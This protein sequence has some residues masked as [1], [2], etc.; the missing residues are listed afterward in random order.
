MSISKLCIER[1]VL[2]IVMNLILLIV[3]YIGFDRLN[4]RELPKTEQFT[5]QISTTYR[6]ASADLV[7]TQIT[8]PIEDRIAGVEGIDVIS[9]TSSSGVSNITITFSANYNINEGMNDVRDQLSRVRKTLPDEADDPVLIKADPNTVP[10]LYIGFGDTKRDALALT[11]YVER[12]IKPDLTQV[13]GVGNVIVYGERRY[14]VRIWP[15]PLKMAARGVTVNDIQAML[16]SQN[17]ALPSGDIKSTYRN[18]TINTES[19]LASI[20]EFRDLIIRDDDNKMVHLTDV[21]DVEIGPE[22]EDTAVRV[23]GAS[24]VVLA[25][26]PQTTA[27]PVDVSNKVQIRL[28]E[29]QRSLPEGMSA[30]VNY[31][32]AT[33]IRASIHEVY[34][35]IYEAIILVTLVV[36]AFLG[37][38]RSA[39]IPIVTIPL[40]LLTTFGVVYA[41][42]YT[43]NTMTLLAMVLAIGLVVDDAI[44][45][46]ENVYRYIEKGDKPM[47][48]AIKGSQEISFAIVAMTLTLAA[49]YAPIGFTQGFTG[50]IF[51]E[52][53]FTLAGAVIISGFVALT[54]SPM[55]CARILPEQHAKNKY[56][57]WVESTFE[58]LTHRYREFINQVLIRRGMVVILFIVIAA[59][60]VLGF[61]SL[62]SELAPHE[63]QGIIVSYVTA[64]TGASFRYTD[65]VMTQLEKVLM[66]V[67]ERE[68]LVLVV[69]AGSTSQGIA[70][71]ALKDWDA[72]KRSQGD[73]AK[74]LM[75]QLMHIPG[76]LMVAL[77]LPPI[78]GSNT[79]RTP[80]DFVIQVSGSYDELYDITERFKTALSQY[81]GLNSVEVDL[82]MDSQQVDVTIDRELAANL[83]IDFGDISDALNI[84]FAGRHIT[85]FESGGENYDVMVQLREAARADPQQLNN[86]YVRGKTGKI[87][88]LA[89]LITFK[90]AVKPNTLPHYNRMRA[91][92]VTANVSAGYALGD[93]ITA[94]EDIA[95]K[96]LPL[97]AKYDWAG[98][99]K[100]FL[101]S[102]GAMG[103]TVV[104]A[105]IF[106]YLVLAAQFES[107]VD[108][109]IIMLTVP[110]SIIGAVITLKLTGGSN[111][112]YTQIGFVTL[113][114]LITK[115]GI[116]MVD[117]ANAARARGFDKYQAVI[118]AGVTR[119]RP[120]LMTTG[121][122]VLGAIPLA[123]ATGPGAEARSQMGWV[124]V[125][126]ML[127][128]TLFSL[129]VVPTIY[130]Y[131]SRGK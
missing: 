114:G 49:V 74:A 95:A 107:F 102:S 56:V 15:D 5:L 4:V 55:M 82:K 118:E 51:R 64:P 71:M 16:V 32:N 98:F 86:I 105:L 92:R 126:G 43:I 9:S 7:E 84:L 124:I 121:A 48:A 52:F 85:D 116:L 41:L 30:K 63:D 61:L 69:G 45:M 36:F 58:S 113:I 6:G 91:A 47:Q 44:V 127:F 75:P 25:I 119:L 26:I 103:V 28:A 78:K 108:P 83:G 76:A 66:A 117:F 81:P 33:F 12:Y 109:L 99:S 1:P 110:F 18:F 31:D 94:V 54:L 72:R 101:E 10:T 128:G 62:K 8:L 79:G 122:M 130:T 106:I 120:I 20:D 17:T 39:V 11:D 37:S 3:G 87:V 29:F 38:F 46:L 115:H 129:V 67:P 22:D 93:A 111:N 19:K 57:D 14:A 2:A 40:C 90:P 88:P 125:G 68:N 97:N 77:D 70:F 104:L 53:A 65:Q 96:T 73:V 35:T 50:D 89:A 123:L 24:A 27:N 23:N 13:E 42:G 60:G 131:L 112:I 100:S 80:V 59:L 34:K 21:A